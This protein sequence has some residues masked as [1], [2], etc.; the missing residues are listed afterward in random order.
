ML[1][2]FFAENLKYSVIQKSSFRLSMLLPTQKIFGGCSQKPTELERLYWFSWNWY[3]WE[4]LLQKKKEIGE[5]K[6][7]CL[8]IDL[9]LELLQKSLCYFH[10]GREFHFLV[11]PRQWDFPKLLGLLGRQRHWRLWNAQTLQQQGLRKFRRMDFVWMYGIVATP[12]LL[13]KKMQL[14]WW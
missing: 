3:F 12:K 8:G 11:C 6:I 1:L 13:E 7:F 4:P 14:T 9:E 2:F 10:V 5:K